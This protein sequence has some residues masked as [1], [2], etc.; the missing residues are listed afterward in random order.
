MSCAT[1]PSASSGKIRHSL[2]SRLFWVMLLKEIDVPE[3]MSSTSS[4]V[5]PSIFTASPCSRM[6]ATT[7]ALIFTALRKAAIEPASAR[8]AAPAVFQSASA[9]PTC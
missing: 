9:R 2:L 5:F 6:C 8:Q 7:S 4:G 1:L 3:M